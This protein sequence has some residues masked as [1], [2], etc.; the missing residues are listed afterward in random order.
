MQE[1]LTKYAY[2]ASKS[3]A[4]IYAQKM[5]KEKMQ[6]SLLNCRRLLYMLL[7]KK[8]G[9]QLSAVSQEQASTIESISDL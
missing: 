6:R 2:R 8:D 4:R 9:L 1:G 7:T 3:L 5:S